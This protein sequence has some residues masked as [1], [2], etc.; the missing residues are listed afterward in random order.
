M[1][2]IKRAGAQSD[3][4]LIGMLVGLLVALFITA[5]TP[6]AAPNAGDAPTATDVTTPATP[7][8][9]PSDAASG[10]A[11]SGDAA[12][13]DVELLPSLSPPSSLLNS[14]WRTDFS[15]RTVEWEEI[16]SGGPPKDGIPAI[17]DP[18][19]E[20]VESAAA[21]LSERDPVILFEHDG[22]VRAYPLAILIWHEI[23]N[24]VVGG[25]PVAVTFCPL[26]NAS[27]VFD[28]TFQ[29]QTLDFGTTGLLRNSD[30]IMYD[31][32]SETWWQQFTGQGI[33]GEWAGERLDFLSSQVI[34]F[35]D[36]AAGFPDAQ[37][38]ARPAAPRSYGANPYT[39]YDSIEGQPFLFSGDV[40]SRLGATQRVV[41]LSVDG[42]SRAYPFDAVA[43]A[44]AV[45]DTI[46]SVPIVVLHKAGTASALDT[47]TI[48]EGRDVGSAAVFDRRLGD[49]TLTFSAND[50]GTFTDA[51]TGTTWNLLGEGI[52]GELSGEQL[53]QVLA[54]DHFWFAWA[55]FHPETELWQPDAS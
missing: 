33:V 44:G 42:V 14:Q 30:L 27:I 41:G 15:R 24:D 6:L 37:V 5:C 25:K 45:N 48:A 11:T 4:A 32:Q 55:A 2:W 8:T 38:L 49:R 12:S 34:S 53:T 31:R 9:A 52:A 35:G 10:D 3:L 23:V 18:T 20:S 28:A 26:C 17:D 50:D 22:D 29:G 39:G 7:T 40:D 36:F 43:A 1:R 13:G 47:R 54:F 16:R 51:E 19:F 46:G 21:W